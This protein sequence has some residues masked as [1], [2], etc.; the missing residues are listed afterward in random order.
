MYADFK[1]LVGDSADNIT[2][3][4]GIGPKTASALLSQYKSLE[5]ILENAYA[6][7]KKN[8]QKVLLDE[9]ERL[10][11]NYQVIKLEG[12]EVLPWELDALEYRQKE[13]KTTEV[14]QS[15]GLM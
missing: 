14:L 15:I 6:L 9:Q 12:T 4:K 11:I 13:Y 7:E 3:A 8:V 1:A 10:R 5:G 2:G